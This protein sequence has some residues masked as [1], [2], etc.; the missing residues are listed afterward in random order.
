MTCQPMM[1]PL[2]NA[3][4]PLS[5]LA[6]RLRSWS[7]SWSNRGDRIT[8]YQILSNLEVSRGNRVDRRKFLDCPKIC[9]DLLRLTGLIFNRDNRIGSYCV[10]TIRNKSHLILN[11]SHP[12]VLTNRDDRSESCNTYSVEVKKMIK[13][14]VSRGPVVASIVINVKDMSTTIVICRILS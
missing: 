1:Y 9:Y 5:R 13:C 8:S 10:L 6:S 14:A 12:I 11:E 7:S 4:F 3:R 2:L